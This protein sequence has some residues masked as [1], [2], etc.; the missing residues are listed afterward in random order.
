M[1]PDL[2]VVIP[3]YEQ[4]DYLADTIRSVL[5]QADVSFELLVSDHASSDDT[6]D[7]ARAFEGDSRV[8]VKRIRAGGGAVANWSAVTSRARGEFIKLLPGDDTVTPGSLAR[9]VELLRAHPDAALVGGRRRIIDAKGRTLARRR[10]LQ[11]L[12]PEMAGGCA[13]RASVRSG[14]NPFGEPGAVMMRRDALEKA[15]GWQGAWSYAID[16]ATYYA[17][18]QHGSF[19][20]D[21]LVASTFRV[22][23]QQWSVAL[24]DRQAEEMSRL[25]ADAGRMFPEVMEADVRRGVRRARGLARQRRMVYRVLGM[26]KR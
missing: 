4:A 22:S 23:G 20:R 26:V 21:D 15:G 14:T 5:G 24:V 3:A 7:V 2:S 12:E 6:F 9:Q 11:G 10:G 17:V 1:R 25:F 13:V 18:L 16:V 8:R 19:V